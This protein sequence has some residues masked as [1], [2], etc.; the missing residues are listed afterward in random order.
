[1][2]G[3]KNANFDEGNP[4]GEPPCKSLVQRSRMLKQKDPSSYYHLSIV[5]PSLVKI[6]ASFFKAQ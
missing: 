1:M 4:F 5:S 6:L 2:I 3:L